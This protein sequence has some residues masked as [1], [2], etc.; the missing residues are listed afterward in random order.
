MGNSNGS[1][2]GAGDLPY[3]FGANA[4]TRQGN[5]PFRSGLFPAKT[6]TRACTYAEIMCISKST[7]PAT[8]EPLTTQFPVRHQERGE[9]CY[10]LWLLWL[11]M[12][13]PANA[14]HQ[15]RNTPNINRFVQT[16]GGSTSCRC[17]RFM[18][19]PTRLTHPS[20]VQLPP[21]YW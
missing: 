13:D 8:R 21:D 2:A 1:I 7:T 20:S 5:T 16:I 12:I 19:A 14:E 18:W 4:E 15:L 6:S 10:A 9:W 3:K 17:G 11:G